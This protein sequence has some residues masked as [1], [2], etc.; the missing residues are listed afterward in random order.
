M[1]DSFFAAVILVVALLPGA[2]SIPQL[3][4]YTLNL[5]NNN[6]NNAMKDHIILNTY[7]YIYDKN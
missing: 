4:Q 5:T 7:I 3:L 1:R 6:N 2:R